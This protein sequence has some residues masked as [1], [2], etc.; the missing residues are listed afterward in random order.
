MI[1]RDESQGQY[2]D[3]APRYIVKE[4]NEINVAAATWRYYFVRSNMLS[5]ANIPQTNIR[6]NN[7]LSSRALPALYITRELRISIRKNRKGKTASS[8]A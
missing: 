5:R 2:R 7:N 6:V 8:E 4:M 3:F 1:L